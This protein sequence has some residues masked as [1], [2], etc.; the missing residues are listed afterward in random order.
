MDQVRRVLFSVTLWL[1]SGA[2]VA[3]AEM[4]LSQR[5]EEPE[6][7]LQH[8][9]FDLLAGV[10]IFFLSSTKDYIDHRLVEKVQSWVNSL[11]A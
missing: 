9:Q 4:Q 1:W 3:E 11:K 5:S 10:Q 6:T 7:C 2:W 8:G